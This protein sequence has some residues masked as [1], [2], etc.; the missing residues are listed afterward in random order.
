MLRS[1]IQRAGTVTNHGEDL[2]MLSIDE[3][4]DVLRG[5]EEPL[6]LLS[7][8]REAYERYRDGPPPPFV[9]RGVA[10]PSPQTPAEPGV[11]ERIIGCAGAPGIVSGTARVV[12]DLGEAA[13]LQPG[14]ILV[15]QFTNVGWTPFFADA[16][17]IVTDI[18]APL[19][20]AAIV[21][22]EFGIP[23]VVGCGTATHAIRTGDQLTV[24]GETGTVTISRVPNQVA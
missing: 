11:I 24:D 15:T 2:Y 8:R 3:I 10:A 21:A 7:D 16:A 23:A 6:R 5:D 19:S 13:E 12:A 1:F 14:E 17:A 4:L 18:G 22:R 20:H 9:F